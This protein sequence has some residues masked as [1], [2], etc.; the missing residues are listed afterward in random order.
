DQL[1]RR[2]QAHNTRQKRGSGA[3]PLGEVAAEMIGDRGRAAIPAGI[4]QPIGPHGVED[5]RRR[6]RDRLAI[7]RSI[8]RLEGIDI[9]ADIEAGI[10]DP[11]SRELHRA[12]RSI[13]SFIT[14]AFVWGLS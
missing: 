12:E 1:D 11:L 9:T 5:E 6:A 7:D 4:D 8:S 14:L 2:R 10:R 13:G 3:Y